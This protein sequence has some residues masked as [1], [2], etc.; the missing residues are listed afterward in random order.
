MG[1][2]D[3]LSRLGHRA[4]ICL[5]EP[6]LGPCFGMKGGAAGGGRSQ[7][8][9]MEDINLHFTG[10][11]HAITTAHN[12]LAALIDNHLHWDNALNLDPERITWKRTMDMNDR[13]LRHLTVGLGGQGVPRSDGFDITAA[14]E[15]M[16]ILCLARIWPICSDARQD[17]G[18]A[19]P[20]R[21]AGHGSGSQG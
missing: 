11:F 16:A 13:A 17:R 14:S 10:D 4:A 1:L 3:G 12:L 8:I 6:S 18:S 7:V 21:G 15:I 9:P 19:D 2:G 20:R 5:R